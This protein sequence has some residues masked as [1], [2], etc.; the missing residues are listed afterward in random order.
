MPMGAAAS[1]PGGTFRRSPVPLGSG[2]RCCPAC[3]CRGPSTGGG[4]GPG[5]GRRGERAQPTARDRAPDRRWAGK[6][7]RPVTQERHQGSEPQ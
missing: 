3:G 4:A 7:G 6:H 1:T 5:P 2:A